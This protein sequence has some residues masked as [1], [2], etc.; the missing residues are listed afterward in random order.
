[1]GV[2]TAFFAFLTGKSYKLLSLSC[3]RFFAGKRFSNKQREEE[4][5]GWPS[6]GGCCRIRAQALFAENIYEC[7]GNWRS[8]CSEPLRGWPKGPNGDCRRIHGKNRQT[9]AQICDYGELTH[10]YG[11]IAIP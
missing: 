1:M 11:N 2:S 3:L 5:D 10:F 4:R 6:Q 9:S 8:R 7:Q